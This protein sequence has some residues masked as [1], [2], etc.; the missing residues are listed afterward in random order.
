MKRTVFFVS[1]RTGI[2]AETLGESLLTQFSSSE[3]ERVHIPFVTSQ[4]K[5]RTAVS[6]IRAAE[7][8]DGAEP[9]VFSTLTDPSV[10]AIIS[11]GSKYVFDLF[12]T[13]IEP[14]EAALG[15]ESS[16]TA[17]KMHGIGDVNVYQKRVDALNFAL[18]H[19]DGLRPKDFDK[20]DVILIGVSRSGKTPT[21]LYLAM[22]FHLKAAN[23]PLNDDD[24]ELSGLPDR[25]RR[26]RGK[27]YGLSIKPEHL[28]KIRHGRR[29]NSTYASLEQC[30]SEVARAE[31]L[32]REE[33]IPHIDTTSVSIEEIATT[34]LHHFGFE[35]P[36]HS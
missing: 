36:P 10:Q 33:D 14:L 26:V 12:G 27:I 34:I 4:D 8:A 6:R 11:S 29:P 17:G 16:H 35:R 15:S 2:T 25:L 24:L 19:D 21:S 5:A 1:D 28:S 22:H 9:L 30:R 20:A 13:F 23:Y 32:F 7:T 31:R 3:F 18:D